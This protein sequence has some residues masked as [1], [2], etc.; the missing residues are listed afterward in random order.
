MLTITGFELPGTVDGQR[1]PAWEALFVHCDHPDGHLDLLGPL[2]A[3]SPVQPEEPH[4]EDARD[5]VVAS[6]LKSSCKSVVYW[7]AEHTAETG[8]W[9]A[10]AASWNE[11]HGFV[12]LE[13]PGLTPLVWAFPG[14]FLGEFQEHWR[15][16]GRA[17]GS[18][19]PPPA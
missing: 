1:I 18:S 16:L 13:R 15:D 14:A 9:R 4:A 3:S 17:A 7:R 12:V 5:A 6:C 10:L 2:F 11:A 19:Q 8:T